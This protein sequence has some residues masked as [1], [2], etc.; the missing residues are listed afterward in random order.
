MTI[1]PLMHHVSCRVFWVKYQI[2]QGTQPLYSPDL[3]PCGF[4]IFQKLKSPLKGKRFQTI[5][6]IQENTMGRLT[7]IGRNVWGPKVPTLRGTEAPFSHVQCFLYLI[8]SLIN[9]SIFHSTWL[10]TFWTYLVTLNTYILPTQMAS[11]ILGTHSM[12]V[13]LTFSGHLL[14]TFVKS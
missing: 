13:F 9:I 8:S 5:D 2:T 14:V 12:M 4:W 6:K 11:L 1:C 7:E 3:V 10:G